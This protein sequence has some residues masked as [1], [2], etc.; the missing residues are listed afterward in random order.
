M[1]PVP[2]YNIYHKHDPYR[3]TSA[4]FCFDLSGSALSSLRKHGRRV[5]NT[6]D[7][8]SQVLSAS[9]GPSQATWTVNS[10]PLAA[11]LIAEMLRMWY[12]LWF[13]IDEKP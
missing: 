13:S 3:Y 12:S 10:S 5:W 7:T 8:G 4:R 2:I 11:H 6:R 9:S 1:N